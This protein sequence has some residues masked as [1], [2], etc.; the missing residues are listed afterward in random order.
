MLK[1]V[2]E[3]NDRQPERLLNAKLDTADERVAVFGLAF[4]P[5]T[6]TSGIPERFPPPRDSTR[7][8]DIVPTTPPLQRTCASSSPRS[9]A[10]IVSIVYVQ[11]TIETLTVTCPSERMI[12][13]SASSPRDESRWLTAHR[14]I[15]RTVRI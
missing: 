7:Y 13:T 3:V 15:S 8:V 11:R 4:N 9:S 14:S 6:T 1:A 10:P 5:A 2:I 12:R